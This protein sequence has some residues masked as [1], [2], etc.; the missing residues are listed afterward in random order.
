MKVVI[1]IPTYN[2]AE[3]IVELLEDVDRR[4]KKLGRYRFGVLVVDDRSPDGTGKL[5]REFQKKHRY[6]QL[7]VGRKTGLGKAMVRGYKYAVEKMKAE[8]VVTNEADFAFS[9]KHLPYMLAK[10]DGGMDVVIGSRHVG[11]GK[12]EGWTLTRRLNHWVANKLFAAWLAGVGEVYDHNGAFRAVRVEGVLDEMDWNKMP[13]GFGFFFYS[14]Y[15]MTKYTTR[16]DE[17]PV[18]YRFRQRGE[19]KVSFNK[20]Y[21]KIY[22]RDV[23]E[24]VW[25]ACLIRWEKVKCLRKK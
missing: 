8:V 14:L 18:I 6:V 11:V 16:I 24:Y 15:E 19:S 20:K 17:F 12:T 1:M 5:V 25:V 2:E 7:L 13:V 4:V 21:I 23:L 3:N 9:F 22:I 10:I